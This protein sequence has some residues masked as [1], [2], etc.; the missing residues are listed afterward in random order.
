LAQG[1]VRL[2]QQR[3]GARSRFQ[4][5]LSKS[6][7]SWRGHLST[8]TSKKIHERS[9]QKPLDSFN[10]STSNKLGFDFGSDSCEKQP[11]KPLKITELFSAVFWN[12]SQILFK[13]AGELV[14]TKGP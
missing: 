10:C 6:E 14:L 9:H 2:T 12:D 4:L 5:T 1:R 3:A 7:Q 11:K 8:K 13:L